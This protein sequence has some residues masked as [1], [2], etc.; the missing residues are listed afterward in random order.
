[1]A[2]GM[3]IVALLMCEHNAVIQIE[4]AGDVKIAGKPTGPLNPG[5]HLYYRSANGIGG[6]PL[7]MVLRF[8]W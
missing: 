4:T 6:L 8:A 1:M 3:S 7:N 5:R 2:W